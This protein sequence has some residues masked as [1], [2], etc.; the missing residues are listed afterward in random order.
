MANEKI[1]SIKIN[2]VTESINAVDSLNKQ[3]NALE[4]LIKALESANIK[5]GVSSVSSSS[6]KG[7]GGNTTVLTQEVAL[8]KELNNLKNEG[9]KIDAKIEASQTEIYKQ[10]QATKELYK[11]VIADQKQME[12]Q[13]RLI[14]NSY[15]NTMAG[16]K[17]HLADLKTMINT[18]DLGDTDKIKQMTQEANELTNKLKEMEEAYGQF[19]RSVGNYKSALD[20]ASD[21][22]TKLT[23][24]VGSTTREFNSSR[25]ASRTLT[26]E[27]VALQLQ[28]K[29]GTEQANNLRSALY[30]LSSAMKDATVSSKAMDTAMDWMKSFSSIASVGKGFQAFFGFDDNEI[31][32]SIQQLVAL[33]GVLQGL[34]VIRKQMETKEGIGKLL[35]KGFDKIDTW[36][37]KLEV[38]NRAI[39]GTGTTARIAAA[40]IKVLGVAL[41]SLMSLG[42]AAVIEAIISAIQ[43]AITATKEWVNGN[44]DLVDSEKLLKVQLDLINASLN[45]RIKLNEALYK[46]GH[47]S[48]VDKEIADE[49][50]L[51]KAIQRT[52]EEI[53]RRLR[54]A[55]ENS[56][57][58]T[59]ASGMQNAGRQ[60]GVNRFLTEDK[61]V[62]TLG[63]F[64]EPA[65]DIDELMKRYNALSDAVE[66]NTGLVYKNAK[67]IEIAHLT[68]SDARDELNHLEQFLA[69][70]MVGAMQKFD[71]STIEGRRGLADFVQ[72][73]VNSNDKLYKS[74]LLRLPE[75]VSNNKGKFGEALQQY[76]DLVRQFA[77]QANTAMQEFKFDEYVNSILDAADETGRR[78]YE[79][80]KKELWQRWEGLNQAQREARLKEFAE[81]QA[82]LD[83]QFKKRQQKLANQ[84]LKDRRRAEK[85]EKDKQ[86]LII[87]T[88]K[89]GLK[90]QLAQLEEER[91]QKL[92]RAKEY[93]VDVVKINAIYDEKIID[94]KRDFYDNLRNMQEDLHKDLLEGEI[95]YLQMSLSNNERYRHQIERQIDAETIQNSPPTDYGVQGVNS[96]KKYTRTKIQEA[97]GATKD[98]NSTFGES[99]EA[100]DK[101]WRQ[102]IELETKLAEDSRKRQEEIAKKQTEDDIHAEQR[103][104]EEMEDA[105]YDYY[106]QQKQLIEDTVTDEQEKEQRLLQLNEEYNQ[107]S[108]K[109]LEDHKKRE[110]EIEAQGKVAIVEALE[111]E[112]DKKRTLNQ[113]YYND[114]LSETS[115]FNTALNQLEQRQPVKNAFGFT[116]WKET[117]KNNKTL[118]QGYEKLVKEIGERKTKLNDL[119]MKGLIDKKV[120]DTTITDLNAFLATLGEKIDSVK[121][122]MS[123][124]NKISTIIQESSQYLQ[125]ASDTFMNIMDAVW[126]WEDKAFD[127]EEKQIEEQLALIEE[128][129][130]KQEDIIK[131]HTD[132]INDIESELATARG[133]RRQEL[134]D[135]LNAEVKAEKKAQKEK[136][137]L[138]AQKKKEEAKQDELERKRQEAE[139]NRSILQATVNGAMAVTFA[140]MNTWPVPAIPMMALAAASTAAQLA[141]IRA[142]RPYA[143]GG[144]LTGPSHSEGGMPILGS[145]IVVEGSEYVIN[146]RTTAQ[147]VDVLDYINSSKKKLSLE[148]FVDFYGG[149][150]RKNIM[151]VR[152]TTRF[153][154]GGIIP[155][156]NSSYNTVSDRLL[157]AFEKYAQHPTVVSVTEIEDKMADVNQIRVLAGLE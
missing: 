101:Y 67:G 20:G 110:K 27:L 123:L 57:N 48:K 80:Q 122:E 21:S 18:T 39:R 45:N 116:N 65:K 149:N 22:T 38:L 86:S 58:Q 111:S 137:K 79:R 138:E 92:E 106:K 133:D 61:G 30:N 8:Q 7:G 114:V 42:I 151:S 143:N 81:A 36:T 148:D 10:V 49:D 119:L 93:G 75:I 24:A 145:D 11:E 26:N 2:G 62:T 70:N 117:D 102:R 64:L 19:G 88:M 156:I 146:K 52:N 5:V 108:E 150:V 14:A 46:A 91:R 104:F 126:A 28:G 25:E 34:E 71:L 155:S 147:N 100:I 109:L 128:M 29:G 153:E 99:L 44:A 130:Q 56:K 51:A 121:E 84:D 54:L 31:T 107:M 142:N 15:S 76:V 118:L 53:Q 6:S 74:L 68:A 3:L 96:F 69:G 129:M 60:S 139:Y 98:P 105:Q 125:A 77:S 127:E 32:K 55:N 33:Q 85:E 17:Q 40:G 41:K 120:Y 13:E 152:P 140:G 87:D 95:D 50:A 124:G 136:Q 144:L 134:I 59:F 115:K 73:I 16:M 4:S 35:G 113:E 90:K 97:V 47:L 89:D 103:R 112:L 141:V 78:Q 131:Q 132:N 37:H 157:T 154:S 12:A 72:G 23:I 94:A 43:K 135:K 83:N 63:G 82:A 1:Y 66:K 9:T